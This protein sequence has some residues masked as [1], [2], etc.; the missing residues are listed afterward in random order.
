MPTLRIDFQDGFADDSVV[1][2]VGGREVYRGDNLRTSRLLG[3]AH[4]VSA[5]VPAGRVMVEVDV[6]SREISG[7]AALDVDSAAYLG[8]SI[9][10]DGISFQPSGGP[11]GYA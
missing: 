10:D 2:R 11:F 8:I 1:V 6:P 7:T 9:A 3:F 4:S 5:D